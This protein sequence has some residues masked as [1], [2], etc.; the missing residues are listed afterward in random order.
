MNIK[1]QRH[2][3]RYPPYHALSSPLHGL[4]LSFRVYEALHSGKKRVWAYGTQEQ[5][6]HLLRKMLLILQNT[7]RTVKTGL[8]DVLSDV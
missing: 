4:K 1:G 3:L 6:F 2:T 7:A 8:K 5:K